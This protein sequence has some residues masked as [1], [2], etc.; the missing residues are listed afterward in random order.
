MAMVAKGYTDGQIGGA[1][2][3]SKFTIRNSVSEI[4]GKLNMKSRTELAA[5]AGQY[6]LLNEPEIISGNEDASTKAD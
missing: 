3:L 6:G 1:L 5:F 4:R 2:D